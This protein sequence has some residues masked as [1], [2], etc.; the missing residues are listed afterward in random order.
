MPFGYEPEVQLVLPYVG[1]FAYSIGRQSWLIDASKIL[2]IQPGWEFADEQAVEGLGHASLLVN[3]A[4]AVVDELLGCGSRQGGGTSFGPAQSSPKLWLLTQYFLAEAEGFT[5]L[6]ADEWLIQVVELASDRPRTVSRP[7]ARTVAR[8]KEFLHAHGYDRVSLERVAN[9][10]L[11][12][13]PGA[14]LHLIVGDEIRQVA[15]AVHNLA[16][17]IA[18]LGR[19]TVQRCRASPSAERRRPLVANRSRESPQ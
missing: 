7:S 2:L 15:R 11:S 13:R 18:Q 8:A 9:A 10:A 19:S 14:V 17:P 12:D 3:P 16:E 1:L 5:N 6:E 4:Q